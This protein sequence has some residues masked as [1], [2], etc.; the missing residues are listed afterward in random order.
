MLALGAFWAFLVGIFCS[1][2][3]T[4]N[5][6]SGEFALTMASL[7]AVRGVTVVLQSCSTLVCCPLR[8]CR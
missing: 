3:S 1:C 5:P 2:L 8:G 4:L 7:N 6:A